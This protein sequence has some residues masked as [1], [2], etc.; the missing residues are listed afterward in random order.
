VLYSSRRFRVQRVHHPTVL[1]QV[2]EASQ[3]IENNRPSVEWNRTALVF[4]RGAAR[5]SLTA[6]GR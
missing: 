4:S 1:A 5:V 2:R 3:F 6:V